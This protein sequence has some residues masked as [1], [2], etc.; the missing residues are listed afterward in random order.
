[1]KTAWPMFAILFVIAHS[2][3]AQKAPLPEELLKAKK[4]Y[5]INEAGV[6]DTFNQLYQEFVKWKRFEIVKSQEEADI[7]VIVSILKTTATVGVMSG[8]IGVMGPVEYNRIHFSI[9]NSKTKLPLWSDSDD[10]GFRT[11]RTLPKLVN[12]LKKRMEGK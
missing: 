6:Q 12:A 5:L 10:V 2:A 9:V 4:A 11:K 1:M 7:L 3:L 8:G